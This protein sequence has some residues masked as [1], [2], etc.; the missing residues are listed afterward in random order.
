MT[1]IIPNEDV[2]RLGAIAF[3][4]DTN[5]TAALVRSI[6]VT[7]YIEEAFD[8]GARLVFVAPDGTERE[9]EFR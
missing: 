5:R 3:R 6:R 2:S 4:H 9:I 8:R 7:A 1:A